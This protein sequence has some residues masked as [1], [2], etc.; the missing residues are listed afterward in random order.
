MG[1]PLVKVFP[2]PPGE[3]RCGH[4]GAEDVGGCGREERGTDGDTGGKGGGRMRMRDGR[5]RKRWTVFDGVMS[6]GEGKGRYCVHCG[7]KTD[8]KGR[9]CMAFYGGGENEKGDPHGLLGRKK[10]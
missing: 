8:V 9:L 7:G 1:T 4:D 5:E 2:A 3:T 10:S 6:S